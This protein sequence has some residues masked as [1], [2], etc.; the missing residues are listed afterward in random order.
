MD[1]K[2]AQV[3]IMELQRLRSLLRNQLINQLLMPHNLQLLEI[4][5][6]VKVVRNQRKRQKLKVHLRKN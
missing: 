4:L 2:V 6:V 5:L 3:K 1:G